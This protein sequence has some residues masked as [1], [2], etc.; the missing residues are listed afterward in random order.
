MKFTLT[1]ALTALTLFVGTMS[2]AMAQT[3]TLVA[4]DHDGLLVP[5]GEGP[6]TEAWEAALTRAMQAP[7]ARERWGKDARAWAEKNLDWRVITDAFE[8]LML[9]DE[10]EAA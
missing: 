8:A 1:Q 3:A 4:D 2:T 6:S 9:P 10:S 5:A 7:A